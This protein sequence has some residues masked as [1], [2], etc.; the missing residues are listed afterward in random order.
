MHQNKK[1]KAYN[2]EQSLNRGTKIEY[3]KKVATKNQ[4]VGEGGWVEKPSYATCELWPRHVKKN[5]LVFFHI[6]ERILF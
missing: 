3:S 2:F 5:L 4:L 6:I 1:F